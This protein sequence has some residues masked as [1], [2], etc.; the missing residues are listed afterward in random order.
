MTQ[1]DCSINRVK[2]TKKRQNR[3]QNR[4]MEKTVLINKKAGFTI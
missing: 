1:Y 4:R 3:E 2:P